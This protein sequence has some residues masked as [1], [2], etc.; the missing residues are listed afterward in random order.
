MRRNPYI[1]FALVAVCFAFTIEVGTRDLG[2]ELTWFNRLSPEQSA[3]VRYCAI[4]V[5]AL[6]IIASFVH[7]KRGQ[8]GP[9]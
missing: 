5:A 6:L 9:R 3:W 7:R 2:H 8:A 1:W 4:T